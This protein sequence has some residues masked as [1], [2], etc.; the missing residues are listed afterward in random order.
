MYEGDT[1]GGSF[2]SGGNLY[3]S[4]SFKYAKVSAKVLPILGFSDFF[5]EE[6]DEKAG[7]ALASSSFKFTVLAVLFDL[8]I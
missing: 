6:E 5:I 3:K 7:W 8:I 2:F 4:V 1:Y